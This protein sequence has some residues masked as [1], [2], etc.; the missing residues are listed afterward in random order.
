MLIK[1]NIIYA[2]YL[3]FKEAF[4]YLS[5]HDFFYTK[6]TQSLVIDSHASNLKSI[7]GPYKEVE[8]DFILTVKIH[9]NKNFLFQQHFERLCILLNTTMPTT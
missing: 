8:I 3:Y 9:I 7:K 4:A 5:M 1:L 2:T 6:N